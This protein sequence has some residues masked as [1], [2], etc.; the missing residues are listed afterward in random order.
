MKVMKIRENRLSLAF[1]FVLRGAYSLMSLGFMVLIAKAF[2]AT[3]EAD[4]FFLAQVF[5]I[6]VGYQ[7]KEAIYL[8]FVS[9]YSQVRIEVGESQSIRFAGLCFFFILTVIAAVT[10]FYN[11]ITPELLYRYSSLI[12]VPKALYIK[13]IVYL[14]PLIVLLPLFGILESILYSQGCFILTA[15]ANL[16]LYGFGIL[17]ILIFTQSHNILIPALGLTLGCVVQFLVALGGVARRIPLRNFFF[18]L[19]EAELWGYFKLFLKKVLPTLYIASFLQFGFIIQR[20][21]AFLTGE[22]GVALITYASR[23]TFFAPLLMVNAFVLPSLP[24][25]SMS[26]A[27]KKMEA[28]ALQIKEMTKTVILFA[29]PIFI[30]M[31]FFREDLIRLFLQRGVFSATDTSKL[32]MLLLFAL[33]AMLPVMVISIYRQS[34]IALNR[35]RQL[36]VASTISIIFGVSLS[37]AFM[38]HLGV[39]GIIL[40]ITVSIFLQFF[41]LWGFLKNEIGHLWSLKDGAF[42]LKIAGLS[43][44]ALI[45]ASLIDRLFHK[46]SIGSLL[47]NVLLNFIIYLTLFLLGVLNTTT[48]KLLPILSSLDHPTQM[49]RK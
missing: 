7:L 20:F 42:I 31:L 32:S 48:V 23:I 15:G 27:Q 45:L 19:H 40:G 46:T 2:G 26:L 10:L 13:L 14:S 16:F 5:P 34:L 37:L 44:L 28:F 39:K 47:I 30:W 3:A 9:I 35:M 1:L 24:S 36:M 4:L 6:L 25:L 22:G 49:R 38:P 11:L 8:S 17:F 43:F 33:P 29:W 21:L 41:M 18:S 12:N